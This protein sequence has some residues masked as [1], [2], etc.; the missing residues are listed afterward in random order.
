MAMATRPHLASMA[1]SMSTV[2]LVS[3]DGMF[4]LANNSSFIDFNP[5]KHVFLLNF[6]LLFPCQVLADC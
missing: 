1:V 2:P 4:Q 6:D 5:R 3:G